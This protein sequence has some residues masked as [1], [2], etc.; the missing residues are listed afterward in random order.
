MN[1]IGNVV[2]RGNVSSCEKRKPSPSA[3]RASRLVWVGALLPALVVLALLTGWCG[4]GG[5]FA[6]QP[7]GAPATG[8]PPPAN[9]FAGHW[10]GEW[11]ALGVTDGQPATQFGSIDMLISPDGDVAGA[12]TNR[13]AGNVS[14]PILDGHVDYDGNME[15]SYSYGVQI[16]P[17]GRV[18]DSP[19]I[20][21]Q[22]TVRIRNG[23]LVGGGP[24]GSFK[25][26]RVG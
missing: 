18:I 7:V 15:F 2:E 19:P 20:T 11:Q 9:P 23:W 13:S 6:G 17:L 5:A 1:G 3:A 26:K 22:G 16:T 12:I 24:G 25:L 14:T 4:Q 10:R 8:G 21:V